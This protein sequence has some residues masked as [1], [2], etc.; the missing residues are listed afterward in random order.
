MNIDEAKRWLKQ[1]E[2]D[3][4]SSRDSS[5]MNHHEWACFQ[6]QQSGEKALK[7]FLYL[8][9]LRTI[10]THSLKDLI[11]ECG[12]FEKL[13][14]ALDDHARFLDTFYIPTRYP[15]GLPGLNIPSEFYT[16]TEAEKCIKSAESILKNVKKFIKT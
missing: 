7:A 12:K 11:K 13:F 3:L 9:G 10:V 5:K 1:A 14:L 16:Q 4:R 6:A 15:N 2:A 8:K